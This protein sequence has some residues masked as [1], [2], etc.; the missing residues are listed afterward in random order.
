MDPRREW[1]LSRYPIFLEHQA[2]KTAGQFFPPLYEEYF[3][4]WGPAP[5][6]EQISE[7]GGDIAIATAVFR[8]KEETVRYFNFYKDKAS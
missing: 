7:A 6:E 1:L 2:N 4:K 3:S 8:Q 5:T